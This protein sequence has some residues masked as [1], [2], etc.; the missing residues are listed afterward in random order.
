[1]GATLLAGAQA[2]EQRAVRGGYASDLL[3]DV[4]A[5]AAEG[6]LWVTLQRHVNVI[7]VARLKDL[8]GVVLTGGRRLE[9]EALARAES[10]GVPILATDLPCWEVVGL[11]RELGVR[12]RR[13]A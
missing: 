11:L 4:M 2:A 10:E 7:A 6:D 12:G 3:S 1:L 8:A 5:N 9:P 13:P